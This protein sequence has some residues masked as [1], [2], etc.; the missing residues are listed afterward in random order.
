MLWIPTIKG[1]YRLEK[2][3]FYPN[4][5]SG[6]PNSIALYDSAFSSN[7]KLSQ[8]LAHELAHEL[9]RNLGD[10]DRRGYM[11]ATQ[12]FEQRIGNKTY[13]V[14]GRSD[15]QFI[16][17]DGMNSPAEDFSNNIEAFLFNPKK[18][19]SISPSAYKWI[20]HHFGDKLKLGS[21]GK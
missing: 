15:G 5:A 12:W 13:T 2:S 8:I 18:L 17:A 1:L 16:E 19:E 10:A 6:E 20:Q 3:V 7:E 21:R 11:V 4:P 9:F 14:R